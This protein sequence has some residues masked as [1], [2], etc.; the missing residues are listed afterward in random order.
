MKRFVFEGEI[1]WISG[2]GNGILMGE[3]EKELGACSSGIANQVQE[4][5][6]RVAGVEEFNCVPSPPIIGTQ[7]IIT[8]QER[9]GGGRWCSSS[10]LARTRCGTPHAGTSEDCTRSR[11]EAPE[12]LHL[13]DLWDYP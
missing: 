3:P 8:G 4:I 13:Q 7:K 2:Q 10:P 1:V 9:P 5:E 12:T 11:R 6:G